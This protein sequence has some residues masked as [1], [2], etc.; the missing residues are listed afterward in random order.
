MEAT[1]GV[2]LLAGGTHP[3]WRTRN[4]ILPLSG[5]TYLEIIGPDP[6]LP[7]DPPRIFG[8]A[9]LRAPRLATWA[10]KGTGLA[11]LAAQADARGIRLGAVSAG[12]RLRADGTSLN[13]ELTDPFEDRFNGMVPFLIDWGDSPHPAESGPAQVTLAEFHAEDPEPVRLETQL[14]AAG[15]D[16]RVEAGSVSRLVARLISPGGA[17]TLVG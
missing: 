4:A 8:L 10:A 11:G 15:L 1:S 17:V 9:T 7:G 6:D 2:R 16:L 12:S 14:R 3:A 13:W 5:T